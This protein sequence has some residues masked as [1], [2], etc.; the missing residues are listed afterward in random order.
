MVGP[1]CTLLNVLFG[2]VCPFVETQMDKFGF[3]GKMFLQR[4]KQSVL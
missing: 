3:V 2:D 1:F 4:Y